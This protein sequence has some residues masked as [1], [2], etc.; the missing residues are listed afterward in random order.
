MNGDE[1]W[2]EAE[3]KQKDK[4]REGDTEVDKEYLCERLLV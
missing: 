4:D 1:R 3:R 2:S